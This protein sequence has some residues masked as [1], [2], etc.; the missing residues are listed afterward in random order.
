M[1]MKEENQKSSMNI[2]ELE[3]WYNSFQVGDVLFKDGTNFVSR[4][5]Q[6]E[7]KTKK[8]ERRLRKDD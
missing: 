5:K 3:K 6:K 2:E 7:K 4:L 8:N 1:I